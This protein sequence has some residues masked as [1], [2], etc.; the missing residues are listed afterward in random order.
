MFRRVDRYMVRE[1][2][3]PFGVALLAFLAFIALQVVI[4]LSD[5]VLSRGAGAGELFTL[6]GLKLPSLLTLAIPGGVLLAIFWALGRM[7]AAR[8][9]LAFQAVGYS[10]RRLSRSLILFGIVMSALSFCLSEYVVPRTEELYRREYMSLVLGGRAVAPEE[11]VFF[12]GPRGNLYYVHRYAGGQ[13]RGIVVYDVAGRVAPPAGDFPAVITAKEGGFSEGE[14][15]LRDGRILHFDREGRLVRVD[16]FERLRIEVG[17]DIE[18]LILGGKTPAQMSLRELSARIEAMERAGVDPRGLIVEYHAKIVV[19]ASSFLFALFGAPVGMVLGKRGRV[20]GAAAG[21][22]LAGAAQ[23]LFLWT[24]TMARQGLIPPVWGA[25]LPAV[26]FLALGL[27][28]LWRLNGRRFLLFLLMCV[29]LGL[30]AAPP[31]FS[32]EAEDLEFS[33]AERAFSATGVTARFEGYVLT[34]RDLRGREGD[35]WALVAEEAELSGEDISFSAASL[36]VM[37][38]PEGRTRS[39]HAR[40]LAGELRF[41]GPEK[42]EVLVFEAE[43]VWAELAEGDIRRLVAEEI[44]FTTCPCLAGAPYA[45]R[46]ARI[47]YIPDQWLFA[48]DLYLSSFGATV[49]WLP[50]YVSR[51][52]DEGSALF[53]RVG[54]SGG[55]LFLAWAL[56]FTLAEE[57]WGTVG[58]TFYPR[59]I[60][61]KPELSLF[62]EDGQLS[63]SQRMLRFGGRGEWEGGTWR[64]N[65]S[66]AEGR[67]RAGFSGTF[68]S[69]NWKATWERVERKAGTYEKAPELSLSRSFSVS[70]G[71]ASLSLSGGRYLGDGTETYRVGGEVSFKW[72]DKWGPFSLALPLG[73]R[74]DLYFAEDQSSRYRTSFSPSISLEGVRF[75]YDARWGAGTSPLGFD[76]LPL[77]SRVSLTFSGA[78]GSWSQSLA[79]SWDLARGRALQGRWTLSAKAPDLS[80]SLNFDPY[81]LRFGTLKGNLS[82][83][84]D[85][86]NLHVQGEMKFAPPTFQD[87][88]AK[89]TLSI[90]GLS[91]KWGV[92]ASPYPLRL[93]RVTL[94]VS[95]KTSPDYLL[96]LAGEYD[97]LA[98]R[99]VQGRVSLVRNFAGCLRLGVEA[100]LRQL[101]ISFEVPAFPGAKW[102]FSPQDEALR[103][104]D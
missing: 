84:G 62:W 26:P 40:S 2:L 72:G 29:P 17:S 63:I 36:E 39:F 49:W 71:K 10:L 95:W 83:K 50:F 14:M 60:R 7:A 94:Y 65:L 19:A 76:S 13:A 33:L 86:W 38:D 54:F 80:L 31:P 88:I 46:A 4:Y 93:K 20:A 56:P 87:L 97:F 78:E 45:V 21:F 35:S 61:L 16:G 75:G 79:L 100:G 99:A 41:R 102:R 32:L 67:T 30:T 73:A 82:V 96:I 74:L 6:L 68:S 42:E 12:R 69:W 53:P 44:S 92:R 48:R 101:G 1:L 64:G 8:E 22:L 37:F 27:A 59:E 51:L 5:V 90:E 34:A 98:G 3:P 70:G 28:L 81:P 66:L 25:W 43:E 11:E 18:R 85:G 52:G 9:L 55:E 104:G 77:Q 91:V 103:W 47:V 23:A 57:L 89:G 58:I 15:E 24:K